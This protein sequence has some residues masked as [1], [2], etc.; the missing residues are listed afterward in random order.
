[1]KECGPRTFSTAE[2]NSGR[3]AGVGE[4]FLV[5][6]GQTE[7]PVFW[8]ME[9]VRRDSTVE[10]GVEVLKVMRVAAMEV[11]SFWEGIFVGWWQVVWVK[12]KMEQ[13]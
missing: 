12:S 3:P 11:V 5:T 8:R 13:E 2:T 7:G 9:V 1:M 4:M 10:K 6:A